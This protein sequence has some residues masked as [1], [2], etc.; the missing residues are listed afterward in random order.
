MK[1]LFFISNLGGGGAERVLVTLCSEMAKRG[2]EVA[3]SVN[4]RI[5]VYETI[6]DVEIIYATNDDKAAS[7]NFITRPLRQLINYFHYFKTTQRIIREKQ[8]DVI[9]SFLQCNLLQILAY[10]GHIP[11][12]SSER[13]AFDRRLGFSNYINRFV[14]NRFVDKVTLLTPFDKGYAVAKGLHNTVIMPNPLPWP[15]ISDEVYRKT[16]DKRFNILA[17]GRIDQWK[18]K[19]F[20]L[21][22]ESFALVKDN[23]PNWTL[24]IAGKG[25]D[26]NINYLKD[27]AKNKGVDN[28]RIRFLGFNSDVKK[29]M[30]EYSLFILS[31]RTEGFPNV[32]IESMSVGTPVIS[33][34]RLANSIIVD[35][36]D[37]LLVEDE[38]VKALSSAM[39]LLMSDSELRFNM[40]LNSLHNVSRFSTSRIVD[41]W[42]SIFESVR[43]ESEY[44]NNGI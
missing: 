35:S 23:Y 44:E 24:D 39:D 26:R 5:K 28:N 43:K 34:E 36:I 33:F 4:K 31:S 40:G 25:E 30:S 37:G 32:V 15:V 9:V 18:V 3:L 19:G 22:I 7:G 6:P 12:I 17:C 10:H 21:L 16:F 13:N 41:K 2:H 1:L 20:D 14:F 29:L 11:I 27:L 38:S 42:E 8:P